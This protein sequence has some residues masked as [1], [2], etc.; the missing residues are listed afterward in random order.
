M[1]KSAKIVFIGA[2][3]MSFGLTMFRDM[4]FSE[5]LHGSTLVLVDT[6][7]VALERMAALGRRLAEAAGAGVVIETTTERRTALP[8]ADFVVNATAIDRLRLWRLDYEIPKKHGIRQTLGENGGPGGLFF[9]LRTLPMVFDFVRDI[10]ALCPDALFINFSNPESRIV[11]A[12]GKYAKVR[13]LGLCEGIFGARSQVAHILGRPAETIDVWGAGLNHFQWLLHIRDHDSGADLYPLLREKEAAHDP[14]FIP[15]DRTLFRSF[16]LWPTCG[17]SHTGEFLPYG[18]EAD[19]GDDRGYDFAGDERVRAEF[20]ATVEGVL[21][22]TAAIPNWWMQPSGE[23]GAAVI[24]GVVHNEKRFIESG[25]VYNRGVIPNLPADLAVEVP[26]VADAAGI[27]PVSLGPLPEPIARL[28]AVQAGVQQLA[29]EA[30]VHGSRELALE[31]LLID[32]VVAST[33]A[34]TAVL[35]EL[36]E[37]NRPY[38]RACV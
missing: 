16:G 32:P 3:S 19:G 6:D 30:A 34:A 35:D 29:V 36:W 5:D 14:A 4:F 9:T 22:G 7:P 10:E 8:G 1:S 38:I 12:L 15:L 21:A 37:V 18:W 25:I 31:A 20:R 17:D 11:M 33:A 2:G 28:L 13:T 26:I 23:R 24:A 27:H